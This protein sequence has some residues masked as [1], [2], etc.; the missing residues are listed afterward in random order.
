MN[1]TIEPMHLL[2]TIAPTDIDPEEPTGDPSAYKPRS[3]ARAVVFD[4][5][6]RVALMHVSKHGYYKLPGGG[7]EP[8]EEPAGALEREL[9]EELGCE[10][11]VTR[12]V[13]TIVTYFLERWHE[14]Q[15]DTCYI[16]MKAGDGT[17]VSLTDF[18]IEEGQEAVWVA[19]IEEAI[20]LVGDARPEAMDGKLIQQ[21]DVTFLKEAAK[22]I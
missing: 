13:G 16:A 1:A 12:E 20:R 21:R 8:G 10:S 2:R 19:T 6:Q 22:L 14:V 15:T 4:D 17:A 7:L 5:N 18:E 11:R 9:L 3:A